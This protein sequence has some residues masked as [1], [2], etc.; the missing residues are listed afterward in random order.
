MICTNV[1]GYTYLTPTR[2]NFISF[3]PDFINFRITSG[4][5]FF[6]R[7]STTMQLVSIHRTAFSA[8]SSGSNS[9]RFVPSDFSHN[10]C[11]NPWMSMLS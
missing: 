9:S 5:I 4:F 8:M 10:I 7:Q 6:V 3:S 1:N 11:F 2:F